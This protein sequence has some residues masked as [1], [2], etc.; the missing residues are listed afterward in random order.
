MKAKIGYPTVEEDLEVVRAMRKAT[1]NE[2]AIMV[3][4]NQSLTPPEAV[5]RLRVLDEE[6]LTWV[7]EPVLAHDYQGHA[8]VA[9]E[10]KTP[11][12]CGENWWGL[13]DMRQAVEARA[14][15]YMMPDVM[16]IG[17]VTG[18]MRAAALGEACGIPSRIISGRKSARNSCVPRRPRISSNTPTGGTR[19]LP[20]HFRLSRG[21]R[22]SKA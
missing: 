12:Q 22:L 10:I 8:L 19:C 2:M 15:D 9:R 13:H 11:I 4:Y 3:D 16:K 20:N 17:G 18:W 21:G 6:G 7:E 14:S 1:G 5:R